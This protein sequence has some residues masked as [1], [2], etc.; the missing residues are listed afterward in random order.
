MCGFNAGLQN[1]WL[2]TQ[3]ISRQVEISRATITLQSV[4]VTFDVVF[5]SDCASNPSCIEALSLYVWETSAPDDISAADT[6]NYHFIGNMTADSSEL[7]LTFMT[8][9]SGFYLGIRD[10]G[11]CVGGMNLGALNRVLVTYKSCPSDTVGLVS[12]AEAVAG[13]EGVPGQC[14]GNSSAVEG[15]GA[16]LSCSDSGDWSVLSGCECDRG[17]WLLES[18]KC[19]GEYCVM[20][21]VC[22]CKYMHV[23]IQV[24]KTTL[25]WS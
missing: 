3:H 1:N 4:E 13:T 14:V 8:Q 17:Y 24:N 10:N 23:C 16:L 15:G 7:T 25:E 11:T 12:V 22:V 21:V 18:Q 6:N 20:T 2:I 19:V 9:H 5:S